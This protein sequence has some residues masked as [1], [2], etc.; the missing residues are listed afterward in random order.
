M[1]NFMNTRNIQPNMS[2]LKFC[3]FCVLC[4]RD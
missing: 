3:I 2:I 4:N 1:W